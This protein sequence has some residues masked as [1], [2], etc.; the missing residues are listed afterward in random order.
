ML[1]EN[2]VV[3]VLFDE[4]KRASGIEFRPN[5]DFQ[6]DGGF[7]K[8]KA[9]KM[10]VVAC[11]ALATPS[12][13]ERSGVGNPDILK[14]AGI[15]VVADVR[16]VGEDYQDHHLL[17]YGYKTSLN[18]DETVDSIITG[19][20]DP[21]SLVANK[22]KLIGWNAQDVSAKLR[23]TDSDIAALGPDF[24]TAWNKDYK[25]HPD[26]PLVLMSLVSG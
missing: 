26:K 13:L 12:V 7:Q 5:P 8:V 19:R 1:V 20:L 22:S 4:Q 3:R 10:V 2:Q 21:A 16:G 11:G 24:Q 14:K 25:D 9:R 6:S 15:N 23:P 17:Q 18:P